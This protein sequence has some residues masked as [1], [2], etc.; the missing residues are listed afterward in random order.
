[1]M[2][3]AARLSVGLRG[4]ALAERAY[5]QALDYARN[6][7]Q[8]TPGGHERD[9]TAAHHPASGREAHAADD[10]RVHGGMRGA[11]LYAAQQLDLGA[12]A[13]DAAPR[14]ARQARGDLLIP[15]V[16]AWSTELGIESPPSAC[17][18]TAA[19]ATSR[20]RARRSITGTSASRPSTR[21]RPASRP[22]TSSAA[23]SAAIGGAA[24]N[25]LVADMLRDLD[26][27]AADPALRPCAAPAAEAVRLLAKT[28]GR[29]LELIAA[30]PAAGFGVAV[31]FLRLAGTAIGGW[32]LV[33]S[34]GIAAQRLAA[35]TPE[36][37]FYAAKLQTARFYVEQLLPA[38]LQYAAV[39]A[40]GAASVAEADAALF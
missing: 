1:M 5:Q 23:R 31:H 3:N 24:M 13:A 36:R 27:L 6:R 22:T 25:A 26:G 38:T 37:E 7:V 20:R 29:L 28:T 11:G 2:M 35:G 17:R 40:G 18:C 19:W 10:A 16:K 4:L 12:G 34:A 9:G 30:Q 14:T 32:L 39:V 15:I 8:G 33:R 21:V